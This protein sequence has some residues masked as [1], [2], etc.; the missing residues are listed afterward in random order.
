MGNLS[1]LSLFFVLIYFGKKKE[2]KKTNIT[3]MYNIC[4]LQLTDKVCLFVWRNVIY[5]NTIK[6]KINLVISAVNIAR[7]NIS[8]QEVLLL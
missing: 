8:R 6:H 4:D 5:I 7:T 2:T 3:C 1:Y